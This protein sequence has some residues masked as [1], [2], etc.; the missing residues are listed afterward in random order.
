MEKILRNIDPLIVLTWLAPF[1]WLIG[2]PV[3]AGLFLVCYLFLHPRFDNHFHYSGKLG[4]FAG[5]DWSCILM[6]LLVGSVVL[7]IIPPFAVSLF[8]PAVVAFCGLCLGYIVGERRDKIIAERMSHIRSFNIDK[9]TPADEP[10]LIRRC[11]ERFKH[12]VEYNTERAIKHF[13]LRERHALMST[14]EDS[15]RTERKR[16]RKLLK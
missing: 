4:W 2:K 14:N 8:G 3:E 12:E 11:Q 9:L 16:M 15:S 10:E 5:R 7:Y 1:S 6:T 13:I